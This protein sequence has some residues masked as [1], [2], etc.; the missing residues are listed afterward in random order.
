MTKLS[1]LP[2]NYQIRRS[3]RATKARI[4]VAPDKIEVVAPPCVSET[5]LHQFVVTN[6]QWI[7]KTLKKIESKIRLYS[8]IFPESYEHGAQI[9]YLG[10]L[11]PLIVRPTHLKKV[12]IEFSDSFIAFVPES[13]VNDRISDAIK[14]ALIGWMKKQIKFQVEL[15]VQRYAPVKNLFPRSISIKSQK[16]RWGSCSAHNDIYI[17]WVLIFAPPDVLEYVVIHE[18]C[19][20]QVKNHSQFFWNLVAYHFPDYRIHRS[21]LKLNG[22]IILQGLT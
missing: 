9:P 10:S 12:K 14:L 2:F 3:H 19:H 4:V 13:I 6:Q 18:L 16:T 8:D 5:I 22:F 11:Y 17:N 1:T 7:L 20:I 15:I 21:W